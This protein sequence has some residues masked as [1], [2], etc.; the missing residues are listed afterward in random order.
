MTCYDD[1]SIKTLRKVIATMNEMYVRLFKETLK[2]KHHYATHYP[3]LIEKFGPLRYMSSM[4]YEAKHK[5]VKSYT[6]N[7]ISRKNISYSLGRKLQYEFAHFLKGSVALEDHFESSKAKLKT[8]NDEDFFPLMKP[9][10]ELDSLSE[11]PLFVCD[12]VKINGVT[13]SSKLYL[14]YING[15]ELQLFKIVKIL[16]SSMD[17]AS[18]IRIIY[19]KYAVVD[20][21]SRYASYVVKDLLPEM[22]IMNVSCVINQRI[23]PVVLHDAVGL[24]MFRYKTF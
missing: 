12:K 6:K 1:S 15:N 7:T 24:K 13:L 23:Y 21:Y 17:D 11:Q 10:S 2:P 18:S 14:P 3:T 19:Q 20:Y 22:N 5:F 8:I 16:M 9:S 4:R